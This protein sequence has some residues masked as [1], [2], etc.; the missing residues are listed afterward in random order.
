MIQNLWK[1]H[2]LDLYKGFSKIVC[3]LKIRLKTFETGPALGLDTLAAF[4]A[5]RKE[6]ICSTSIYF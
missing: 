1:N 3:T 2:H 4:D 6:E 5:E